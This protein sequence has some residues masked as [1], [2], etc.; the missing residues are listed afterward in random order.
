MYY[1]ILLCVANTDF[2][3]KSPITYGW[4]V[5]LCCGKL[6]SGH[7]DN[8]KKEEYNKNNCDISCS[9]EIALLDFY[10]YLDQYI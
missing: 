8:F 3:N 7:P 2:N 9:D 6:F 1:N 5:C 4:F 10:L